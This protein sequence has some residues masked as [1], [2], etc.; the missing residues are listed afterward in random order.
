MLAAFAGGCKPKSV[1]TLPLLDKTAFDTILDGKQ[2]S[3]YTLKNEKGIAVQ[4]T[5]YG[6]RIVAVWVPAKDGSRQD[7]AWG[8]GS[9]GDYLRATDVYAG[10]IVGRYGNRIAKGCFT[11]D[12]KEY[13]LT[14]NNG[15]NHLH[16]GT[17]GW[18]NRVWDAE[19]GTDA[20]GNPCV[21]M[22]YLSPDGEEGYP[23]SVSIR[24]TYTL[25]G[26]NGLSIAYAA[27]TD[28]PTPVNPTSH[29]YFNLHGTSEKSTNTHRLTIHADSFTPTDSGLIP[30]GEIRSVAG[31]PL[32]FRSSTVIGERIDSDY[33]PIV[34]GK[35]YDHNWILN[36]ADNG[37]K[38]SFAAEVYE[39]ET[40][41]VM[42]V[43]TDQPGLQFY[44]GNFMDGIDVDKHGN[45][46]N[47][48]SG[49]ALEAQNYPD[50]PNHAGF[51]VS[52]LLPG[53]TYY[54]CTV[55]SFTVK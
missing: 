48:R 9:I 14:V 46:H 25:T 42:R 33:E 12:G 47:Y 13:R 40:G 32:D 29:V 55:Y 30:T 10:P 24:V 22:S 19:E 35:G 28:A 38:L 54:Q 52:I 8:Y 37:G 1:A 31:T 4:L 2:V 16:G 50:A 41:I 7:V 39:P 49:I 36:R 20:E 5:N 34:F 23:G 51:P 11:L 27:V 44:S 6:A 15:E 43:D 21:V 45:R 53:E 26:D 18:W 17:N 3:L